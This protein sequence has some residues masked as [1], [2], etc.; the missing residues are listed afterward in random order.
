[1]F[2]N[3]LFSNFLLF[4]FINYLKNNEAVRDIQEG[5]EISISYVDSSIDKDEKVRLLATQYFIHHECS[6]TDRE[7]LEANNKSKLISMKS[8]IKEQKKKAKEAMAATKTK[9]ASPPTSSVPPTAPIP[10]ALTPSTV[11]QEDI[12]EIDASSSGNVIDA[13][14]GEKEKLLNSKNKLEMELKKLSIERDKLRIA[15]AEKKE[16]DTN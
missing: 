12:I 1:L 2:S 8:K 13:D 5:E 15:V 6:Q 9:S 14:H 11:E 4:L 3:F 16:K 7:A 10:S